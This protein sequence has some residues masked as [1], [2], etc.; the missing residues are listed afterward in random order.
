MRR[1]D[2]SLQNSTADWNC[3]RGLRLNVTLTYVDCINT[4]TTTHSDSPDVT[5]SLI[6]S[7][8]G[9]CLATK[10]YDVSECIYS[11]V[12]LLALVEIVRYY[13]NV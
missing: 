3:R 10:Y 6:C 7:A 1:V 4:S 12:V 11:I 2:D 13:D 8:H 9:R 5:T